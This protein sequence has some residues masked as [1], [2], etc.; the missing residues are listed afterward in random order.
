VWGPTLGRVCWDRTA[1]AVAI[2]TSASVCFFSVRHFEMRP[3]S[4]V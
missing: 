1:D 2:D 3:T 4:K